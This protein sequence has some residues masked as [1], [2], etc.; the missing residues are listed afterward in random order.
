MN[1]VREGFREGGFKAAT[2]RITDDYM[3]Q[4]P[5][6]ATTSIEE[7]KDRLQRYAEAGATRI[8]IPYVPAGDDVVEDARRFLSAWEAGAG[9]P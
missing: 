3:D 9:R 8:I 6:L 4:L 2:A 5:A 1:A 7:V